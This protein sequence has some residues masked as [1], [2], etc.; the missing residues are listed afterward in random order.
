MAEDL[1]KGNRKDPQG[2]YNH[3]QNPNDT[4]RVTCNFCGKTTKGGI[5]S[6]KQ[7]LIGNFRNAAKCLNCPQEVRDE[8]RNY[9]EDK[10][11]RKEVYTNE[12][13][14][15]DE[16]DYQDDV[17]GEDEVQEIIHKKR[18]GGSF[19]SSSSKKLAKGKGPMDVF[20]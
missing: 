18:G 1:S 16:F 4:T 13:S 2:K 8:L 19:P 7:H 14:G 15:L 3:L 20:L 12:F 10:K 6:A 9:M 17:G 5:N 11:L